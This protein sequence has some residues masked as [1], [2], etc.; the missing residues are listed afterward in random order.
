MNDETER[1]TERYY[2]DLKTRIYLSGI[3]PQQI[4][5]IIEAIDGKKQEDEGFE[6]FAKPLT[7][8]EMENYIPLSAQE[9]SGGLEALR[10]LG[11]SLTDS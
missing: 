6:E 4:P 2:Q 10:T 9:V 1:E 8:E 7:D 3:Q 5:S 11:F